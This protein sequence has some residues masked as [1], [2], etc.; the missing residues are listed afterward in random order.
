MLEID[1]WENRA[2]K[3]SQ[4]I[5]AVPFCWHRDSDPPWS[6]DFLVGMISESSFSY[7]GLFIG[8]YRL[9][10]INYWLWWSVIEKLTLVDVSRLE[11]LPAQIDPLS[12]RTAIVLEE[13]DQIDWLASIRR[14]PKAANRLSSSNYPN[15]GC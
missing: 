1:Q 5:R 15:T 8:T 10:I 7:Y 13:I 14:V 6:F 4:V 12:L 9:L 3:E 2:N 11:A